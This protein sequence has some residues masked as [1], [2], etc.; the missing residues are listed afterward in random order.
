MK[1]NR[2]LLA[3]MVIQIVGAMYSQ[4]I[5][6]SLF[7]SG[8]QTGDNHYDAVNIL[9]TQSIES[10]KTTY[11]A[12][13]TI[14]LK[15]GFH[16][17]TG[18]EFRGFIDD[19][20]SRL[21]IMTY[22]IWVDSQKFDEHAPI[23][24]QSKPN[25][26]AIQE[27]KGR[28]NFN[29]LKNDIGLDGIMCV[30]EGKFI[31]PFNWLKADYGICLFWDSSLG[32]PV[33]KDTLIVSSSGDADKRRAYIIAEF[34]EFCFIS[35][36]YSLAQDDRIKMTN[37]ILNES[38]VVNCINS[39]KP[40]YIAGDMNEGPNGP[41]IDLF[42]N[43]NFE[44]LNKVNFPKHSTSQNYAYIDLIFEFNSNQ[45]NELFFRGIPDGADKDFIVSDHLPYFVKLNYK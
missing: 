3:I 24:N 18:S 16:A 12:S 25:L 45:K 43:A 17:K 14:T 34:D 11:S 30:T 40:V 41:A 37:A 7:L 38:I 31:W 19:F 4:N 15:P 26:L 6:D 44:I 27:M 22:N 32:T 8:S 10:D 33:T 21:N 28:P 13:N 42:T 39:N 23:I 29:K 35:T 2:L 5:P 36:H 1:I 9:S 20:S